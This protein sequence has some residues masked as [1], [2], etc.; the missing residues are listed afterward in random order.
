MDYQVRLVKSNCTRQL[1]LGL[2]LWGLL[3][4]NNQTLDADKA[5]NDLHILNS[6]LCK[7]ILEWGKY[8]HA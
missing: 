4:A 5:G 6:R 7:L 3:P 8:L 1:P 2:K